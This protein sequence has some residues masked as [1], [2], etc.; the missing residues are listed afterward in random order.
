MRQ[1]SEKSRKN[2]RPPRIRVP[3][4]EK[5]IFTVDNQKFIGVIKRLSIT[6]GSAVLPKDTIPP[7]THGEMVLKTVF[8]KVEA[9]IQFL[10]TGADGMPL[11]Q[12]FCFLDMD[13]SSRERFNA[14]AE[15]MQREGFS[16]AKEERNALD[17]SLSKLGA[18]IRRLSGA[19]SPSR[20]DGAKR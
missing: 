20:R 14:A 11:V 6:G 13:E 16:D 3:N 8:G 5:A 17:L 2:T 7:G 4:D 18:S 12:A 19:I 15:R 1:K 10:H 9:H